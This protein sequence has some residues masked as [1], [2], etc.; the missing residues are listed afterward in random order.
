M[1]EKHKKNKDR[2]EQGGG[3]AILKGSEL[4]DFVVHLSFLKLICKASLIFKSNLELALS[5]TL[6]QRKSMSQSMLQWS[7]DV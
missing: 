5:I 7:V 6:K 2:K 1:K 4:T 3:N